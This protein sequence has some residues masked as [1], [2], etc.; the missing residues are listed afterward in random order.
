MRSGAR[1]AL[2]YER[3]RM[4]TTDQR[5]PCARSRKST[6]WSGAPGFDQVEVT[7]L[8]TYGS[9]SIGRACTR[10]DVPAA[11][12][13]WRGIVYA[14]RLR[15]SGSPGTAPTET[16]GV[17]VSAIAFTSFLANPSASASATDSMV[18]GVGVEVGPRPTV[19]SPRIRRVVRI[20]STSGSGDP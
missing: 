11:N 5:S 14:T 7:N 9:F 15:V 8:P 10:T 19:A 16:H 3:G 1:L 6:R 12:S 20:P 17:I 2:C 18:R 4:A 13:V